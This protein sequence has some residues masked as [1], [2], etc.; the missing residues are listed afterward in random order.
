MDID[1]LVM[2]AA[3]Q[4]GVYATDAETYSG[5]AGSTLSAITYPDETSATTL[6][7]ACMAEGIPARAYGQT[8]VILHEG[9][10]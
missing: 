2:T 5:P 1:S 7:R 10:R 6:A 9:D 4:H 3:A 8:G